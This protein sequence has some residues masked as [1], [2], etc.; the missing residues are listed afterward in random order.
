MARSKGP[1]PGRK[2]KSSQ[3]KA[4]RFSFVAGE[5]TL[6]RKA[7]FASVTTDEKCAGTVT[8]PIPEEDDDYSDGKVAGWLVTAVFAEA[9][10]AKFAGSSGFFPTATIKVPAER[11]SQELKLHV[12]GQPEVTYGVCFTV[13][14]KIINEIVFG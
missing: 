3:P 6:P 4:P 9:G 14:P 10:K 12:V 13:T 1:T 8:V 5:I 7:V 11:R 2:V